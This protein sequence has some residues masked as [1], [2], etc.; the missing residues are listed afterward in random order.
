MVLT[1]EH[2]GEVVRAHTVDETFLGG[3]Q[4]LHAVGGGGE[5]VDGAEQLSFEKLLHGVAGRLEHDE[6]A[7]ATADNNSV[8]GH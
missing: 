5:A 8:A 3:G 6:L 1:Q 7:I 2:L 4:Q